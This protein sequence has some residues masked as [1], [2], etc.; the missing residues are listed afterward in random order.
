MKTIGLIGGTGWVSTVE[1]YRLLNEGVRGR[2]GGHEAARCLLYSFNF[3][4]VMRAKHGDPE[5]TKVREMVVDAARR[6]AAIGAE[7]LMLCANTLHWFADD[8]E[9]AVS[10]PLVHVAAATGKRIRAEGLRRV[11]LLGTLPTMER[12]FYRERLAGAGIETLVPD[13][14]ERQF[15]DRAIFGELVLGALPPGYPWRVPRDHQP[16]ASAGRPGDRARLHRDP[17]SAQAGGLQP[18]P[19]STP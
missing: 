5:Q 3:G 12:A 9:R 18:A 17:A 10:L 1:Y 15:V 7:G 2:L 14:V 6:L 4:D 19:C 11:G 16:P 13:E 8:V